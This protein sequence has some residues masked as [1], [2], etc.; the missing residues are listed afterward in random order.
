MNVNQ[1]SPAVIEMLKPII[2]AM[3]TVNMRQ[4]FDQSLGPHTESHDVKEMKKKCVHVIFEDNDYHLAV[5]RQENGMLKCTV[6]GREINT[7]FD[8]DA[9]DTLMAAIP[10]LNG[11]VM[12]GMLI[13]LRPEPLN[14]LISLKSVLPSAAQLQLELNQFVNKTDKNADAVNNLGMEYQTPD[15]FNSITK[16]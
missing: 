7:K 6:C 3:T 9:V 10:V 8:K 4:K 1:V 15:L 14:M 2:D 5:K 13:G 11:L 12:F 16:M